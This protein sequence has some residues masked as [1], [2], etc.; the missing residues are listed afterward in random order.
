MRF[1]KQMQCDIQS[2]CSCCLRGGH[3]SIWK[4]I[5]CRRG[6]LACHVPHQVFC[7]KRRM[8]EHPVTIRTC[9]HTP[10]HRSIPSNPS[11]PDL[12]LQPDHLQD[13]TSTISPRLQTPGSG[14]LMSKSS[15]LSE[16]IE[17]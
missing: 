8:E 1:T 3:E 17:Y 2:P 12:S 15:V 11:A 9:F 7:P 14:T 4:A 10:C 13:K 16:E 5:G 6:P